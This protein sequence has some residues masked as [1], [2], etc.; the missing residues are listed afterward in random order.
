MSLQQKRIA[1]ET[2]VTDQDLEDI[3]TLSEQPGFL[4]QHAEYIQRLK[5][6]QSRGNFWLSIGAIPLGIVLLVC[7]LT[8]ASSY[9]YLLVPLGVLAIVFGPVMLLRNVRQATKGRDQAAQGDGT[10]GG[11]EG[12]ARAFYSNAFGKGWTQTITVEDRLV[13]VSDAIPFSILKRYEQSFLESSKGWAVLQALQTTG[14]PENVNPLECAHCRKTA[15]DSKK[16]DATIPFKKNLVEINDDEGFLQSCDV[17]TQCE[18]CGQALCYRC[19]VTLGLLCPVCG[20]ATNG[21]DGL[22]E[23]WQK[24]RWQSL[25]QG[26]L[27]DVDRV[28]ATEIFKLT[29]MPFSVSEVAHTTRDRPDIADVQV[30]FRVG[31]H[32]VS[33]NNVAVKVGQRWFLTSPE[34]GKDRSAEA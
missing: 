31:G 1:Y 18:S 8:I 9:W 16:S 14:G 25:R 5:K 22:Q 21:W 2:Q 24:V 3:L 30:S 34:P 26:G 10:Q 7:G 28:G 12:V 20:R 23:R 4:A 29:K 33:F 15:P 6:K 19:Y 11:L 32:R 13:E 27:G 17:Y